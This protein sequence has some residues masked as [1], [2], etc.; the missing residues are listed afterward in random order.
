MRGSGLRVSASSNQPTPLYLMRPAIVLETL[1]DHCSFLLGWGEVA[2]R[3]E[4]HGGVLHLRGA[5]AV[6]TEA[7]PRLSIG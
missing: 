6:G 2:R 1:E 3:R 5:A 4:P 7:S